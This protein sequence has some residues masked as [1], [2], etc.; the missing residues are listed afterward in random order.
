MTTQRTRP[1]ARRAPARPKIASPDELEAAWATR[2][3]DPEA[4]TPRPWVTIPE[5]AAFGR[6]AR[7]RAPRSSHGALELAPG[8]DPVA[9]ILA[10]E[11][12]RLQDLLPL[13]HGRMADSAFAFYR[14][15]PAVMALRPV[16]DAAQRHHRPGQRRRPP[17]QLRP[18]R[19]AG[20]D[21]R[22]RRER[23]RR[24]AARAVGV[25]RQAARGQRRHRRPQQRL[26]ARPRRGPRPSRRSRAYR[27]QMARYAEM[28]AARHLVRPDDRRP[29]SRH[30]L[31]EAGKRPS[32]GP[33]KDAKAAPPGDL[34]QGPR[35]GPDEGE[36]LADRDRRRP[37]AHHG[38]SAGRQPTSSSRA[39]P[40]R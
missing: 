33:P 22:L 1:T 34:R 19:L 2:Q 10:Q 32:I 30:Q 7:Q 17:V 16:D 31:I 26:H 11:A 14:G 39:A 5:R 3:P 36:R 18:V 25:G 4:W 9:I 23:L 35:Q 37:M 13:R 29:T 21:A 40:P 27:E 12:D 24:D 20:A 8:R 6:D 15:A 38:R 28:R